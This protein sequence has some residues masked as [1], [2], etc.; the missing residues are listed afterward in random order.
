MRLSYPLI[1]AIIF[2][3]ALLV[4]EQAKTQ[5]SISAEHADSPGPFADIESWRYPNGLQVYFKAMPKTE[6]VT[7]RM[8]IPVGGWQDPDKRTGL[9]HF[10][11]HMLFTGSKGYSKAEFKKLIDDKGGQN[12]AST[13]TRRTDY[14]LELPDKEWEFGLDW[15]SQLLFN[16]QFKSKHVDEERRAVILERDLK[17]ET[18]LDLLNKW[19]ISPDWIKTQDQWTQVLGLQIP[20]RSL[21]GSWDDVNAIQADDIQAFYDRYYGPQNMTIMLAGN[22]PRDKVKALI[23]Q[24]FSTI[25]PHGEY[26][27]TFKPAKPVYHH[28]RHY[29]FSE[30]RGHLHE[31]RHY[32]TDIDKQ[33]MQWLWFL[34]ALLHHDLNTELRQNRQ[35]AYGVNVSFNLIQGHG[36]LISNGN[37]DPEQEQEAFDYSNKIYEQLRNG[38]MPQEQFETL[39]KKLLDAIVLDHQSPWNISN[40]VASMFFDKNL[41]GEGFP[42]LYLFA[43][44]ASSSDLA[45]WMTDNIKDELS[46]VRTQRPNPTWPLV[47]VA[48]FVLTII[49]SFSMGRRF[50]IKPLNLKQ[51]LYTRKIVYGPLLS[52]LALL[53][54]FCATLLII[55]ALAYSSRL[56]Q[57]YVISTIDSYWVES[58]WILLLLALATIVI[59]NIPARVP[60][61]IIL[62]EDHWRIKCLSYRSRCYQYDDVVELEERYLITTLFS[63]KA[64]PCRLLHWN[65]FSKGLLIKLRKSSYFIK[66]RD[67]QE[68]I[69]QFKLRR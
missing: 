3:L 53:A 33:D 42:D 59:M 41:I 11:E 37:F 14:W 45:Q 23:E 54:F 2:C 61:K 31:W 60:R 64:F 22:F 63:A 39:R 5:P 51:H 7:F 30:R 17:P 49:F 44:Q 43:K 12:N 26:I 38:T 21:I 57:R 34:R 20:Y 36:R 52:L 48:F 40:W 66:M 50:L 16:H 18:P 9:A 35:A 15:F 58:G 6:V 65:P 25:E 19:F 27:Q 62:A 29:N 4:S 56:F 69:Q 55:Q 28:R 8:T 68:L 1:T 67:H 10:T 24:K 32:I 47:N 46:V 13:S